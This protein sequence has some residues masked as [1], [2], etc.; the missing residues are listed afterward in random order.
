MICTGSTGPVLRRCSGDPRVAGTGRNSFRPLV[1][2]PRDRWSGQPDLAGDH[3]AGRALAVR[4][5]PE[6]LGALRGAARPGVSLPS[7]RGGLT[8]APLPP[9]RITIADRP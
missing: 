9:D 3:R 7:R 4:F 5:R 1:A 6:P 8:T 2:V